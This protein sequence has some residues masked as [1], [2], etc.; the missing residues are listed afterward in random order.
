MTDDFN[1]TFAFTHNAFKMHVSSMAG[2]IT[3]TSRADGSLPGFTCYSIE[4]FHVPSIFH[5][6]WQAWNREYANARAIFG[7]EEGSATLRQAIRVQFAALYREGLLRTRTG[8]IQ[9]A[10]DFFELLD[11]GCRNG[12]PQFFTYVLTDERFRFSE[13]GI[14]FTKDFFSKHSMHSNCAE[15]VLL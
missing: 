5:D 8:R 13:S 1:S 9:C 7:Q 4:M 11:H 6:T 10:N 3:F 2:I 15:Q 12:M 14:E